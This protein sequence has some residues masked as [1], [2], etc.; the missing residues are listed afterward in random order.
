[1]VIKDYKII[2]H[3]NLNAEALVTAIPIG[4]W[5]GIN[6]ES[7]IVLD[8]HNE[9]NGCSI[10]GKVL[11]MPFDKGSCS[12]S[13]VIFEMLRRGTAPAAMIC[14][15]ASP[16]LAMGPIISHRIYDRSMPI[17]TVSEEQMKQIRTGDRISFTD[18]SIL[19]ESE[20]E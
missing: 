8:V 6:V 1:M 17:R 7:G 12:G 3:G 5:G 14:I 10:S 18:D 2:V 4:F 20:G 13:G 9:L 19:I 11:C 15:E 16:I